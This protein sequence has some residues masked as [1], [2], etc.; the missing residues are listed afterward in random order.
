MSPQTNVY[1]QKRGITDT[2]KTDSSDRW[3]I[4]ELPG[5]I[6]LELHAGAVPALVLV[7]GNSR[8]RVELTRVKALV[9]ALTDAAADLT[10]DLASRGTHHA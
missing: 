10:D 5:G 8:I 4:R 7:Q 6:A 3:E 2:D 9:A 1:L